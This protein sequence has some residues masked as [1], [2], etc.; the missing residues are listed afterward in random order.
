MEQ[1][2]KSRPLAAA[3]SVIGTEDMM[4]V[5]MAAKASAVPIPTNV[6]PMTTAT[7]ESAYNTRPT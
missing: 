6:E 7:T 3:V 5:G 1:T 4:S 2:R